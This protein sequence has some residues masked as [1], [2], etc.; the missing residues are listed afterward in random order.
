MNKP[1]RFISLAASLLAALAVGAC[2]TPNA[3]IEKARSTAYQTDYP[4]VW[5]AVVAAT[6]SE[7]YDR[8]KVEDAV[9]GRLVT[10]WHK[11]ERVADSQSTDP[12]VRGGMD[13]SGAIFFRVVVQIEGKQP[14]YKVLVDGEAARYRPGFSSLFPYKH[15]GEDE[16]EWVNGRINAMYVAVLN[17]LEQYAV[18]PSAVQ[19]QRAD[20]AAGSAPR[21]PL[22]GQAPS[23]LG[24]GGVPGGVPGA[25]TPPTEPVAPDGDPPKAPQ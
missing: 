1:I 10:D 4:V 22:P 14:P 24:P 19:A 17:Q 11:I 18:A 9:N 20:V 8:I 23:T 15:G 3:R 16:P 6:K 25:P 2:A 21:K 7:G 13:T 12:R 5:N